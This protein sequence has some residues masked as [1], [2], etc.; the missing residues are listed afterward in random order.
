MLSSDGKIVELQGTR[1]ID[2]M[3]VPQGKKV[4]VCAR[5][6]N[7]DSKSH[8][9]QVRLLADPIIPGEPLYAYPFGNTGPFPSGYTVDLGKVVMTEASARKL[10]AKLSAGEETTKP[11]LILQLSNETAA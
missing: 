3:P 1:E 4:H 6:V 10:V 11:Q 8:T 5:F 2:V 9:P 7:L